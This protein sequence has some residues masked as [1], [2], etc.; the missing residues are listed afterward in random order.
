MECALGQLGKDLGHRVDAL[1]HLQIGNCQQLRAVSSEMSVEKI[2]HEEHL[3]EYVD[4][5]EKF[6][7]DELVGVGVVLSNCLLQVLHHHDPLLVDRLPLGVQGEV[8]E[9]REEQGDF[10]SLQIFPEEVGEIA[11]DGLEEEDE[12]DPLIPG[13]SDLISL[14]GD[15]HQVA[16]LIGGCV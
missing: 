12:Y 11:G 8:R 4:Q 5:I 14:R 9:V 10:A 13:M 2:V 6:T 16:V 3:S 1:F 7:E 15:L